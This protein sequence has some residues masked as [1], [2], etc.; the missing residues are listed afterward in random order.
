MG[1]TDIGPPV[2]GDTVVVAAASGTV[3]SLVGQVAEP[4]GC[5][6]VGIASGAAKGR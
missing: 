5:R 2:P 6:V 4:K 1:L 3:G